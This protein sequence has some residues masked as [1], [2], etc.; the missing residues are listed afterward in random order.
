VAQEKLSFEEFLAPIDASVHGFVQH[1]HEYLLN[2]GCKATFEEKK[3]GLLG[4]YKHTKSKKSL[5]NILAKKQGVIV[6][7]YGTN[8]SKYMDF[9]NT[10][11]KSMVQAIDDA[12][13]CR[14]LTK[15]ECSPKCSG[16]DITIGTQHFQKCRYDGFMFLVTDE[17]GPYIK[18]FIEHEINA[19]MAV[20]M[21]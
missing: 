3:T 16:Y 12:S 21:V 2:N 13:E 17:S 15:N 5:I 6:R 20:C 18:S 1:L 7:I 10:L 19:R 8:A 11:P 14:R 9:L 4:S